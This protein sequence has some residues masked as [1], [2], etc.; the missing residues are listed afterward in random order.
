[1]CLG[2]G[3]DEIA[4]LLIQRGAETNFRIDAGPF[5]VKSSREIIYTNAEICDKDLSILILAAAANCMRTVWLLIGRGEDEGKKRAPNGFTALHE[6]ARHNSW[7]A[8]TI[9]NDNGFDI[10][11]RLYL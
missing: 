6:A 11:A 8:A 9:L 7:Q 10:E 2:Q 3:P 5:H 1:M 4:C